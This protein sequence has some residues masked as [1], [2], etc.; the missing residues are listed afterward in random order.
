MDSKLQKQLLAVD[1]MIQNIFFD[2]DGTLTDPKEGITGCIQFAL[3]RL[4]R[5]VPAS[6]ELLW[7]IGP[8]LKKSFASLLES[9]NIELIDSAL[10]YYRQRF[11]EIGIYENVVYPEVVD[12]LQTI[13]ASGFRVFLA[14]SKPK[15]FALRVLEHF[16]LSRFF[17]G[18]YGSELDGRLS[19]KTELVA[20]ILKAE[21]LNPQDSLMVGDRF[22]DIIGGKENGVA[23]A[24]VTYGYGSSEEIE[25]AC[26]DLIFHS[27]D[28][29][30]VYLGKT[31]RPASRLN[32]C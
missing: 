14:T 32:P 30:A 1:T 25:K 6:D 8:P 7:C 4:A 9:D 21:G 12:A 2:L 29:L 31:D 23:T 17:H 22:Y 10:H 24:A 28:D 20:H 27:P 15:V 11:A 18:I 16:D 13:F 19:D 5:K 26:P 3:T